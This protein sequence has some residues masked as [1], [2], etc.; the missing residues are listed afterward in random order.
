MSAAFAKGDGAT[1]EVLYRNGLV[2]KPT[3]S[4][5]LDGMRGKDTY[6]EGF[7]QHE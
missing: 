4:V 3:M 7:H 6:N 1:M 2:A 5:F